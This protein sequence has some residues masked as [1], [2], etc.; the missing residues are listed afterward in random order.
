[1]DEWK[2]LTGRCLENC[3]AP[4]RGAHLRLGGTPAP[5]RGN[6]QRD[7]RAGVAAQAEPPGGVGAQTLAERS[8]QPLCLP[9]PLFPTSCPALNSGL[10]A[11]RRLCKHAAPAAV[12]TGFVG[13][14][15]GGVHAPRGGWRWRPPPHVPK[16]R[17]E[18]RRE[19][20]CAATVG[21]PGGSPAEEVGSRA[22]EAKTDGCQRLPSSLGPPS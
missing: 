10:A 11:R 13:A 20:V 9:R 16:D 18:R 17:S 4:A 3:A 2:T 21:A 8:T 12:E 19:R 7:V 5:H 6:V 1:M 14:P 15:G 22:G